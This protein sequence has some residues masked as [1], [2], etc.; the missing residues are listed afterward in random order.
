M[1]KKTLL[2]AMHCTCG[3]SIVAKVSSAELAD[4]MM[5]VF[6]SYHQAEGHEPCY[7]PSRKAR[8]AVHQPIRRPARRKAS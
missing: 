5:Q 1:R 7:P 4:E 2:V 8:P 6:A 3:E